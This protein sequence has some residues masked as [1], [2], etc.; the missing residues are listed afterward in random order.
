MFDYL[1]THRPLPNVGAL[2]S[3]LGR[4][5]RKRLARTLLPLA[6]LKPAFVV[7]TPANFRRSF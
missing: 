1:S 5:F 4:E 6:K 7:R 2:A 3:W